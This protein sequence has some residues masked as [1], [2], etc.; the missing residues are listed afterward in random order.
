L[1]RR[2]SARASSRI[3]EIKMNH[4]KYKELIQLYVY[5]EL[6]AEEKTSL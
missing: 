5:N 2:V 6:N 1:N 3:K 4:E